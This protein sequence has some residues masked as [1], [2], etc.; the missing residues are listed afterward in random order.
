[1]QK[2][3]VC[4]NITTKCNQNCKYC[5]RFLGIND[6]T[7]EENKEILNNLIKD[8]VNNITWTGGEALLYPNLKE[9]LKISQENG[10]KN[11]L[12]TNGMVL[13][14][15]ENMREI[16]GYLDSLTLSLDTINDDTNEELGRGRNHFEEVKTILD[17]VKGKSLKVNINTVVSKK[18]I[19]EMEQLGEFLNNYNISK[20][21]FFKFM[22]LRE[23]AERNK[24][25]FAI[26]DAEFEQTKNVF[27]HF[28]NIGETDFR[29]E[30][31]MEDKYTLLIANGDIIKTEHGVDVKKG[32]ALYQNPVEFMYEL[33]ENRM[34]KI[35][36]L[37]AH[38]NEEIRNKIANKI[39]G[40]DY[41]ELVGTTADGKETYNKIIESKPEVV[42]AKM[43]LDNMDSMEIM[44]KSK[45][46]LKDNVPI[47]NIITSDNV[48]D[49]YMKTAYNLMGR[50][51][52]T[53]VS[54]P[55][56]NMEIDNI[57]QGYKELKENA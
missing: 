18:N 33:E 50:N 24:D 41:V 52:N 15:N 29:Q 47:F 19:N 48:S 46:S 5:H 37:I 12:I 44:R 53:F 9:L 42:F 56:N 27:R 8:G 34:K 45:E 13:A 10:I 21:K 25:E 40:L 11:K 22:P 43:N 17:Y 35:K 28:G 32:N 2:K 23:T 26:T 51:L 20:W 14:Q 7:Y 49:E 1:M 16:L 36:I 39:K 57:M 4:W 3:R 55:I 38:N 54:E 30:K 6:L 31:D